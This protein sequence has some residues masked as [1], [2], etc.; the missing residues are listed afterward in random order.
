MTSHP[1]KTP[2]IS[3]L[4]IIP[5]AKQGVPGISMKMAHTDEQEAAIREAAQAQGLIA[6]NAMTFEPNPF[7]RKVMDDIR[8]DHRSL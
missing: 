5:V 4:R 7:V 3:G 1:N 2:D 8:R 6:G